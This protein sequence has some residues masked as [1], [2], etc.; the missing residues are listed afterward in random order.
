MIPT[1]PK[2]KEEHEAREGAKAKR[3]ERQASMFSVGGSV[4]MPGNMSSLL[5]KV[6]HDATPKEKMDEVMIQCK[7]SGHMTVEQIF[8]I[9]DVNGDENITPQ[10]FEAALLQLGIRQS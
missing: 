8:T 7:L 3:R 10:E 5:K 4:K 1:Q 2:S 6:K 9:F